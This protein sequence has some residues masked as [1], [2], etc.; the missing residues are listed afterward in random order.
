M[1]TVLLLSKGRL[2]PKIREAAATLAAVMGQFWIPLM[3]TSA[4][5]LWSEGW[6]IMAWPWHAVRALANYAGVYPS[7]FSLTVLMPKV[8]KAVLA[9][10]L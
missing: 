6:P 7:A 8:A 2:G 10:R 1:R 4:P 3:L 5:M 9:P